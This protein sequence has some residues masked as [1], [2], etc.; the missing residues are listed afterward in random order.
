MLSPGEALFIPPLWLHSVQG[1]PQ[2]NAAVNVFW[3]VPF[4][5][6]TEIPN[7]F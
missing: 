1:G 6:P 7:E 2:G 4:K 5:D 3:R